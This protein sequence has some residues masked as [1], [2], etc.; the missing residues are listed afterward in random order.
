MFLSYV[1]VSLSL[2][3]S[4]SSSSFVSL[5]IYL[6]KNKKTHKSKQSEHGLA[7]PVTV[8][9]VPVWMYYC[10]PTGGQGIAML[11]CHENTR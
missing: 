9:G 2:S 11:L 10:D 1:D 6:K 7:C 4:S 5:K 8:S 3:F